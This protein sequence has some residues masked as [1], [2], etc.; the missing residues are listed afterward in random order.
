MPSIESELK[1][2]DLRRF[3]I[4][5]ETHQSNIVYLFP[6][7]VNTNNLVYFITDEILWRKKKIG[8]END[9]NP[10]INITTDGDIPIGTDQDLPAKAPA[11]VSSSSSFFGM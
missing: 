7:K 6:K 5:K 10:H 9:K 2:P 1:R 8:T 11:S 3:D 4:S